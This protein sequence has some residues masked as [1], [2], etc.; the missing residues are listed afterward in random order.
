V[1]PCNRER[2]WRREKGAEHC[3]HTQTNHHTT[4]KGKH[5]TMMRIN[6]GSFRYSLSLSAWLIPTDD[7]KVRV[8]AEM[9]NHLDGSQIIS[10][11]ILLLAA[12]DKRPS[13]IA[14]TLR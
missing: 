11:N 3:N 2:R 12:A 10:P 1:P 7:F 9:L 8:T 6:V 14:A 5:Y 13:A 4:G